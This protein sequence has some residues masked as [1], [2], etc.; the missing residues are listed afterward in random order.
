[1]IH[2]SSLI[3]GIILIV[4]SVMINTGFAQ[5]DPQYTQYM[6]NTMSVNPGYAGQRDVL[7]ISGLH[8]SQWVGIDGAPRT[9]SLILHTPLKNDKIGLGLSVVRDGLGPATETYA[10]ANFSYSIRV[11]YNVELSFGLKG[12]FHLLETDW[13]Q[14]IYQNPDTV[15]QEN[16][17]LFSPVVGAGLYLHSE[18]WYVGFAVPNFITTRHYND[19][20]ESVAKE[21]MHYYLIAGLVLQASDNLKIKPATLIKAVPGAP[22]IADLSLNALFSEKFTLGIAYRWD[23]AFS[24]LA[25]FQIS[26]SLFIGYAYDLT[27]TELNNYNSGTHEIMMRFEL[28]QLGKILSPRFF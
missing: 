2:K 6:Y 1:M 13:S 9:Q 12:G 5:Q 25:G 16:L 22:V 11:N 26:D 17:S 21:R 20:Q 18:Y 23:D 15:F 27:A 28:Q 4:F 10:D 8:R 3:K 19:F 7:S 24:G 14:G